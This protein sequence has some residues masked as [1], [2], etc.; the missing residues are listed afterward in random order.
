LDGRGEVG[1]KQCTE[2]AFYHETQPNAE[3]MNAEAE[4]K[5]QPLLDYLAKQ[6]DEEAPANEA[7]R[8]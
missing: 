4:L 1:F 2:W 5:S 3:N 7:P 6:T 8:P